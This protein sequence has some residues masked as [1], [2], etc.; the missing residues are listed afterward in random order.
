MKCISF[1][2]PSYNSEGY[3]HIC[4]D[5]L[6]KG[7]E[8]NEI[9]VVDDGS[10]DRTGQIADEYQAKYPS[11]IRVIHQPNGG[12]GEGINAAL[13]IA[14]GLFFKVVDSDDWAVTDTLLAMTEK[15]KKEND[16]PDLF[17]NPF[18][19]CW[20][21]EKTV[22]LVGF[23]GIFPA[24]GKTVGWS[25]ISHLKTGQFFTIHSCMFKTSLLQAS[26]FLLPQHT[27]YEDNLY[28]Y[29]SLSLV[30]TVQYSSLP[31]YCYLLGRPGQSMN[32]DLG[33]RR[34]KDFLTVCQLAFGAYDLYKIPDKDLRRLLY[35]Q[36]KMIFFT[37]VIHTNVNKTREAKADFR[38]FKKAIRAS[39]PR[40]ARKLLG[41]SSVSCLAWP[42]FLGRL[43]SR[44][45]YWCA[46]FR[47]ESN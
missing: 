14:T 20:G 12:H 5:S 43:N 24:E 7:G 47:R 28:I 10:K 25:E 8:D 41:F 23:N 19:N 30:K 45:V 6:L 42:G 4:L 9:I 21:D 36:I 31:F 46:S 3:L 18:F 29:E 32:R 11:I 22:S 39:N 38:S 17:I 35:H 15:I 13:K 27:F 26:G 44:F 37:A 16:L 34:Y 33:I 2:V 1:A 40:L